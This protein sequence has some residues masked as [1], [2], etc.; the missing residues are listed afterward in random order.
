M[1]KIIILILLIILISGCGLK[2]KKID[3]ES[4]NEIEFTCN[5]D[6][7]TINCDN[8][9]SYYN[10]FGNLTSIVSKNGNSETYKYEYNE[11]NEVIYIE[12]NNLEQIF[13]DYNKNK[14]P[15]TIKYVIDPS[16]PEELKTIITYT[17]VYNEKN[18]PIEIIKSYNN[19]S[20]TD[21][22]KYEYYNENNVDYVKEEKMIGNKKY[23]RIFK[24]D[25][26]FFSN[27]ILETVN[28]LPTIYFNNLKYILYYSISSDDYIYD[29]KQSPIFVPTLK[30]FEI[31]N[32]NDNTSQKTIYYY[33]YK[34]RF[35]TDSKYR[36]IHNFEEKNKNEIVRS[37]IYI[38]KL[39][40]NYI[41]YYQY[42][43]KYIY[44]NELLVKF[45]KYKDKEITQEEYEK[46]KIKYLKKII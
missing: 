36:V 16:S 38:N 3:I 31:I 45:I 40:E 29:Y 34:D 2:N 30:C 17:F 25:N 39:N 22:I 19:I 11:D 15:N 24:N 28:S 1:K 20:V 44:E 10:E 5:I 26:M 35:I 4:Y 43:T 46:L 12:K 27:N 23:I 33:D 32:L 8:E 6:K 18:N 42:E 13:I 41:K 21:S 9:N 37:T 7:N 14:N